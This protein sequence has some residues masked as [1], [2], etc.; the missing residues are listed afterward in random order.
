MHLVLEHPNVEVPLFHPTG[1]K[2]IDLVLNAADKNHDGQLTRLEFC[3]LCVECLMDYPT[4]LLRAGND[5]FV[6]A[7]LQEQRRNAV[8]SAESGL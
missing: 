7:S 1:E 4:E 5:N 6:L 8:R 2:D 3:E